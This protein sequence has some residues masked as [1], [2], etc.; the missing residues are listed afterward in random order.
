M[1]YSDFPP[2]CFN[3]ASKIFILGLVAN[4]APLFGNNMSRQQFFFVA[5]SSSGTIFCDSCLSIDYS[6]RSLG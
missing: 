1:A 4:P 5:E 2:F 6:D 3:W